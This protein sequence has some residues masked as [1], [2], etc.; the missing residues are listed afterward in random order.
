MEFSLKSD[1][2]F[3]IQFQFLG[4]GTTG[5]GENRGRKNKENINEKKI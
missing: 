5:E 4:G 1:A 2:E 3:T